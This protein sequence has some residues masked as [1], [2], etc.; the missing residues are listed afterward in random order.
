MTAADESHCVARVWID[1]TGTVHERLAADTGRTLC[2]LNAGVNNDLEPAGPRVC[3]TCVR[4]HVDAE[5]P[6]SNG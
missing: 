4:R 3:G 6:V 2:G 1:H 5:T